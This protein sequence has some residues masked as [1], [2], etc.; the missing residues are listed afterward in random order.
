MSLL[1]E[2]IRIENGRPMHLSW[3]KQRMERARKEFW[4]IDDQVRL[5]DHIHV[6]PEFQSGLVRC[7][8]YYEKEIHEVNFKNYQKKPI[9][10]LKVIKHDPADY[11]VK[12]TDRA[13][14]QS[15]LDQRG[16]CDE[17]IIIRNGLVTDTSMSN[18]IFSDG[19]S[20]FTPAKPLL[21]GTTRERLLAGEKIVSRNIREEDIYNYEGV[22]LINAMRYPEEEEMINEIMR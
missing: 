21:N 7:N 11:H 4:S 6:P 5:E 15:L 3:H 9:R 2:T 18:L 19:K 22:K 17:I 20:W 12:Y 8:V 14:L 10:S 16:A 1:F 13:F